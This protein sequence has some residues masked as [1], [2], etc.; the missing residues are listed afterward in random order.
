M[1]PE[2]GCHNQDCQPRIV[3]EEGKRFVYA[4]GGLAGVDA[5]LAQEMR[6]LKAE[7]AGVRRDILALAQQLSGG[8]AP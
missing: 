5:Y 6:T 1:I 7:I 4:C 3:W 8:L 2:C